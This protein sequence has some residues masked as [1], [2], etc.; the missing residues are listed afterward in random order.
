MVRGLVL[1]A[2]RDRAVSTEVTRAVWVRVWRS[3][4]RYTPDQGPAIAWVMALAHRTVV[5][6]IR[7]ARRDTTSARVDFTRTGHVDCT[8]TGHVGSGPGS[9]SSP[10]MAARRRAVLQAY[11]E[12]R[13]T[14]QIS[15]TL[16]I[17][18]GTVAIMVHSGLLY[19]RAHL[20]L[21]DNTAVDVGGLD[22]TV[23]AKRGEHAR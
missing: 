22:T 21:A 2:L 20:R 13:T 9:V 16:G 5:E 10:L 4:G 14:E 23:D 17:P 15:A 18:H 12:G 11:Y 1:R 7:S 3:A 19:L 6:R 8:R